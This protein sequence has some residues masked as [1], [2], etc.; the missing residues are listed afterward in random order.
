MEALFTDLAIAA[1]AYAILCRLEI[2]KRLA[3]FDVQVDQRSARLAR[4]QKQRC[5]LGDPD[6]QGVGVVYEVLV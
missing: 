5:S 4:D 2:V 6:R 1:A 3:R